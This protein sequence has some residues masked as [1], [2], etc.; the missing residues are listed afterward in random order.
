[1]SPTCQ[2]NNALL[3]S[4]HEI[5]MGLGRTTNLYMRYELFS[6]NPADM[7]R[8]SPTTVPDNNRQSGLSPKKVPE[9]SSG[10]MIAHTMLVRT[11][12][13]LLGHQS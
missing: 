2:C 4:Q 12:R 11:R 7:V 8:I 5:Y 9:M 13:P 3:N 10:V 1:M 6:P